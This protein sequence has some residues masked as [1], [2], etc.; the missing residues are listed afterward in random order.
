MKVI[1]RRVYRG[2]P[3]HALYLSAR[4]GGGRVPSPMSFEFDG[5][6]WAYR[7]S[8]FCDKGEYDLIWRPDEDADGKPADGPAINKAHRLAGELEMRGSIEYGVQVESAAL[9]RSQDQLLERAQEA[10]RALLPDQRDDNHDG[11]DARDVRNWV[12]TLAAIRA[13]RESK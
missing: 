4:F 5:H 9:I 11:H 8:S 2:T 10:L 6:R 3:E 7:Y 12:A 1:E 13:H